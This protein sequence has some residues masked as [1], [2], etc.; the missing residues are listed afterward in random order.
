MRAVD[1]GKIAAEA[2]KIRL[3][4]LMKRQIRRVVYGVIAV[5]FALFMLAMIHA[6]LWQVLAEQ[7]RPIWASAILLAIDLVL[8][9][10]FGIVGSRSRPSQL[11][12]AAADVRQ[13][14]LKQAGEALSLMVLLPTIG[15]M[16]GRRLRSGLEMAGLLGRTF[17]RSG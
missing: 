14:A 12:K 9:A 3:Q 11:E 1:L 17:R 5:L 10:G 8:A 7:V 15:G 4:Q 2:E 6:L 13:E 16:G